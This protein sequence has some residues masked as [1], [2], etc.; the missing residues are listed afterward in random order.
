MS[1]AMK[2]TLRQW[3]NSVGVRIPTGI[4]AELNLTA[5]RQVDIRAEN[6][7][8]VIEPIAPKATL[9][10]LLSQITSDNVHQAIDFG[11]PVGKELL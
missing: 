7:K 10:Q 2:A 1:V 4:L 6:G 3:G 5:Q 11:E 9:E 8:I